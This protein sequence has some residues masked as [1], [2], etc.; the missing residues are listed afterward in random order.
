MSDEQ[1]NTPFS[2]L[3]KVDEY[4]RQQILDDA[5]YQVEKVNQNTKRAIQAAKE[6]AA[7]QAISVALSA[8]GRVTHKQRMDIIEKAHK[9]FAVHGYA[10]DGD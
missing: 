1:K 6:D 10:K 8:A 4:T 7:S 9:T 2:G 3:E 5:A